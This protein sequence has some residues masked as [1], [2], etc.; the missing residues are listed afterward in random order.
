MAKK[1]KFQC[2]HCPHKS[3]R[4]SNMAV[5]ISRRHNGKGL[6]TPMEND[7]PTA[8]RGAITKLKARSRHVN[9]W[10]DYSRENPKS[11]P[12]YDSWGYSLS[13]AG[14]E[15]D[16]EPTNWLDK[17]IR[18]VQ[19]I[20]SLQQVGGNFRR[21]VHEQPIPPIP[22]IPQLDTFEGVLGYI[23]KTCGRCLTISSIP[24]LRG[25]GGVISEVEHLCSQ[26]R[27]IEVSLYGTD[28]RNNL[29][30]NIETI[31]SESLRRTCKEWSKDGIYLKAFS[32]TANHISATRIDIANI[33]KENW[34]MRTINKSQT[35]VNDAELLEFL[36]M[37]KD[38]TCALVCIYD[39]SGTSQDSLYLISVIRKPFEYIRSV[40]PPYFI[41]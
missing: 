2:P 33:D 4:K 31:V 17:S 14:E 26:D 13:F 23:A 8:Y 21:P 22:Q 6:P 24:F 19:L 27:L 18:L 29:S 12:P 36:Q 37:A 28:V 30:S 39:S 11:F 20:L 15:M 38:K 1:K 9:R 35:S 16:S 25:Q 10:L 3:A 32:A 7:S 5:H 41:D 34:L 40:K